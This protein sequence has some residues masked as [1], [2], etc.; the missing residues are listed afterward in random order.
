MQFRGGISEL[1]KQASRMQ[2]RVEE[3]REANKDRTVEA[4]GANGQVKVTASLARALVRID[5]D[6]ELYASDRELALDAAVAAANVALV[7]A[8]E[9]MDKEIAK[10]TGGAK[11]PGIT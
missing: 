10:V 4:T 9:E 2:R 6:P 5:I 8:G 11:I 7:Q 3:T 1:M